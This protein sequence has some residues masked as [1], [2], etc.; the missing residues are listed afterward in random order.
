M[1]CVVALFSPYVGNVFDCVYLNFRIFFYNFFFNLFIIV[2]I[3][4]ERSGRGDIIQARDGG[5]GMTLSC[6]MHGGKPEL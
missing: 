6:W 1:D 2:F 4:L 3:G 5:G